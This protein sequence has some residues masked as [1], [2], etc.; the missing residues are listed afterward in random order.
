MLDVRMVRAAVTEYLDDAH[1]TGVYTATYREPGDSV[2][3][4]GVTNDLRDDCEGVLRPERNRKQT[5]G[6]CYPVQSRLL[7]TSWPLTGQL[8]RRV[9][10]HHSS[11]GRLK[12]I[13]FDTN[14]VCM[15]RVGDQDPC[16][17]RGRP[18]QKSMP[19]RPA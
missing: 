14:V 16:G 17:P 5:T 9:D 11:L 18:P 7:R 8:E 4:L 10:A 19:S 15:P 12:R 6:S 3:S 13:V 2:C 1:T